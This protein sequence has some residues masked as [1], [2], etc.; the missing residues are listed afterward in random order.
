M[1]KW[2]IMESAT[3]YKHTIS[4]AKCTKNDVNMQIIVAQAADE[5]LNISDINCAFVLCDMGG[6]VIISARSLGTYN[7]QIIMEKLGGGG[8]LTMAATQL[9]N[10]DLDEA[11]TM[12]KKAIDEYFLENK[13]N[14]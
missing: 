3:T 12:L 5:L 14:S 8:H 1:K 11:E 13:I 4:I 7:I 9:N 10:V 2:E 6:S